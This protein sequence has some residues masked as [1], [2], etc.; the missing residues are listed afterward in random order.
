MKPLVVA[1]WKMNTTLADASVLATLVRNQLHD[2]SGVDVVLCPPYIWLQEVASILEVSARHI[3]LGAQNCHP[4]KFGALTGEVS[5]AQ[6][7]DLCQFVIVGHSERR[8]HFHETNEFVSDKVQAVLE[9]GMT[10]ILCVGEKTKSDRSIGLVIDELHQS[11]AGIK[12]AEYEKLVIAYEPIWAIG[13]G[14]ASE[15]VYCE[16]VCDEI[17]KVV[18]KETRVLYGGSVT[19]ENVDRFT[20]LTAI[21]GVLVGGASLKAS[22][23]VELCKKVR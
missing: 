7:K 23:F 3:Y 19:A 20:S 11:L 2:L 8:E 22:E 14:N 21:D 15:A 17:K 18:G 1:N 5:V 4:D 6:V 13:T 10:P 12:P 16:M 9:N